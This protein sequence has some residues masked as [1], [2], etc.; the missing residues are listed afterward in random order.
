LRNYDGCSNGC[1]IEPIK[2]PLWVIGLVLGVSFLTWGC[3]AI[4]TVVFA[5]IA[6]ILLVVYC[7]KLK[8]K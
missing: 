1:H 3:L 7:K 8:E 6:F 4:P 2:K 5:I